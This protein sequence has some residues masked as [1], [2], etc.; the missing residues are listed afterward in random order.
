MSAQSQERKGNT[1][2]AKEVGSACSELQSNPNYDF[3]G[4]G[5]TS[6]PMPKAGTA[7]N[8]NDEPFPSG[9]GKMKRK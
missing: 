6:G 8:A 4:N 1:M 5:P 7:K 2:T 3:S 9:G